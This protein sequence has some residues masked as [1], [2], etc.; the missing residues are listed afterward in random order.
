MT[1]LSPA[2]LPVS[3]Q[4]ED[5]PSSALLLANVVAQWLEHL[6]DTPIRTRELLN[7]AIEDHPTL[8]RA[9]DAA[10]P[11]FA[12]HPHPP[13]LIAWLNEV[14][15]LP[16]KIED[17]RYRVTRVGHRWAILKLKSVTLA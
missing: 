7:A 10:L 3:P 8:L 11:G 1:S 16:V 9:L 17:S 12:N 6:S 2:V 5:A 14:E 4:V 13:R 15:N